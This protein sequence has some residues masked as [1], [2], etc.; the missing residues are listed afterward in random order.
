MNSKE[1]DRYLAIFGVDAKPAGIAALAEIVYLNSGVRY[2][3]SVILP[4][5]GSPNLPGMYVGKEPLPV[6]G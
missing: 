3:V 6:H 5:I 1:V 4:G 2:Q